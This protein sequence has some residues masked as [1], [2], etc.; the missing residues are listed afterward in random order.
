MDVTGLY[1]PVMPKAPSACSKQNKAAASGDLR[2]AELQ[3]PLKDYSNGGWQPMSDKTDM[4]LVPVLSPE[5]CFHSKHSASSGIRGLY[6]CSDMRY[7]T[8][9]NSAFFLEK[10]RVKLSKRR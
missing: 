6:T 5:Y 8:V 2:V 3:V 9:S 10:Y 4:N 7:V 1:I